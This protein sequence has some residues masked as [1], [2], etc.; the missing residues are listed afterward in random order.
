[1]IHG[2][3][4]YKTYKDVY[5]PYGMPDENDFYEDYVKSGTQDNF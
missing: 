2:S 1:M 3:E 4:Y 5:G